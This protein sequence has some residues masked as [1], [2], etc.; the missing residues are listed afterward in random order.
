MD[1]GTTFA[2]TMPGTTRPGVWTSVPIDGLSR[3]ELAVG[4]VECDW[5]RLSKCPREADGGD[6]Q[7]VART[8]FDLPAAFVA[9]GALPPGYGTGLPAGHDAYAVFD[10][11]GHELR[12]RVYATLDVSV[13]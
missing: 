3:L 12:F 4:G 7:A 6:W 10:S 1:S 2:P 8:R 13:D 5:L 9:G 11:T